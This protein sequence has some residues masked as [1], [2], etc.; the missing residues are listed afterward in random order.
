MRSLTATLQRQ[1]AELAA[2][3][4]SAATAAAGVGPRLEALRLE[5]ES[6]RQQVNQASRDCARRCA[7]AEAACAQRAAGAKEAA[8]ASGKELWEGQQG[9]LEDCRAS[10]ASLRGAMEAKDAKRDGQLAELAG[11]VRQA[12]ASALERA[13]AAARGLEELAGRLASL[14]ASDARAGAAPPPQ[15]A[16]Q[17]ERAR[18]ADLARELQ[19]A[20]E[21][22]RG[23]AKGLWAEALALRRGA[24]GL[25]RAALAS[26]PRGAAEEEAGRTLLPP[27]S[28]GVDTKELREV[29]SRLQRHI[30]ATQEAQE[31]ALARAEAAL[32]AEARAVAAE[33]AAG[34]TAEAA[35]QVEDRAAVRWQ[36]ARQEAA[37][38]R[39][40]LR[41]DLEQRLA[42]SQETQRRSLAEARQ[43]LQDLRTSAQVQSERAVREAK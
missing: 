39:R 20:R 35:S 1:Q 25:A 3:P 6:L 36:A 31:R 16:D 41:D 17:A 11:L 23:E 40:R 12:E 26:A 38:E 10:M 33:V 21:E 19:A 8:L 42:L 15:P 30:G 18:V 13:A 37:E 29:E 32:R 4:Q 28:G 2:A 7:E 43:D 22:W 27:S 5:V 34:A 24:E 14:E 9:L